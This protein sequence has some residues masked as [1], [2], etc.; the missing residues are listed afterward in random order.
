MAYKDPKKF[1]NNLNQ[2][3]SCFIDAIDLK[4]PS[5]SGFKLFKKKI[6]SV[7]NTIEEEL[8]DKEVKEI[9]EQPHGVISSI[10]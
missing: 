9:F 3:L 2:S 1:S 6:D 10:D 8:S 5:L 7:K 4:E